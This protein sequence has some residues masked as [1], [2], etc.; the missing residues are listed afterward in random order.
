VRQNK[1]TN[2]NNNNNNNKNTHKQEDKA[3][4]ASRSVLMRCHSGLGVDRIGK[5]GELV[6]ACKARC[7]V[8]VAVGALFARH[9]G[10]KPKRKRVKQQQA[11]THTHTHTHTPA[12]TPA[13]T[14]THTHTH[15]QRTVALATSCSSSSSAPPRRLARSWRIDSRS[16]ACAAGLFCAASAACVQQREQANNMTAP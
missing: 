12:H 10:G 6:H 11:H 13:H 4:V 2:N 1:Q 15:T 3:R 8:V 14:H 9:M 7:R 16:S 5:A